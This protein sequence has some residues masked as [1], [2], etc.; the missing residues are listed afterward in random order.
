MPWCD[1]VL[2]LVLSV[3]VGTFCS[4]WAPF[5]G[6]CDLICDLL[7]I[8]IEL[9][10]P[11][12]FILSQSTHFDRQM[13]R[14]NPSTIAHFNGVRC[15]LKLSECW[16]VGDIMIIVPAVVKVVVA[17]AAAAAAVIL[18]VIILVFYIRLHKATGSDV[19][20]GFLGDRISICPLNSWRLLW[21]VCFETKLVK[22]AGTVI[23]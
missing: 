20:S 6:L 14:Q 21:K 8:I 18:M 4:S 17:A 9:F 11:G 19:S 12:A 5:V 15:A 23:N 16:T 1:T 2:G 13:D 22:S 10:S 3:L 7:F